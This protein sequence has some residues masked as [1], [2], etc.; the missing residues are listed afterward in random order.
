MDNLLLCK[1]SWAKHDNLTHRSWILTQGH[2]KKAQS[3][4]RHMGLCAVPSTLQVLV[5]MRRYEDARNVSLELLVQV[6]QNEVRDLQVWEEV[7]YTSAYVIGMPD[8]SY[9]MPLMFCHHKPQYPHWLACSSRYWSKCLHFFQFFESP[10]LYTI[11]KV[12]ITLQLR[13]LDIS[14]S[15]IFTDTNHFLY[16]PCI[17][18]LPFVHAPKG[19]RGNDGCSGCGQCGCVAVSKSVLQ[20]RKS[21]KLC[22]PLHIKICWRNGMHTPQLQY[23]SSQPNFPTRQNHSYQLHLCFLHQVKSEIVE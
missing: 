19:N 11:T 23:V 18:F 8:T 12:A 2:L 9:A 21:Y 17:G 16:N 15:R 6:F 4:S 22:I 5:S 7:C 10:M 14:L 20:S 3:S 13:P 1:G